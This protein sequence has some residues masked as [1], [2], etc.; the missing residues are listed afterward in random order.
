MEIEKAV[1]AADAIIVCL[2]KS[3]ITKEGY[4]QKEIKTALDFADYKPEGTVFIIPV[5]LED[6]KPPKRF[7]KWQYEDYFNDKR[8]RAFKRLLVS[9]R[10]RADSLGLQLTL[11]DVPLD[12][13]DLS[14]QVFNSLMRV[15]LTNVGD[16]LDLLEMGETAV[17]SIRNFGEKSLDELR[18]KMHEKGYTEKQD[19][20]Q[21]TVSIISPVNVEITSK[22]TEKK[23]IVESQTTPL[24]A[25]P[26]PEWITANKI[27]LSNGMEFMRVPT[28]KFLMG[29]AKENK[30][31]FDNEYPQQ[32]I[33]I[34]YDY[35]M[36]RFPVTNEFYNAYVKSKGVDHPVSDWEIKKDHPVV[37]VKWI[38]ALE[39]CQ[40][41]ND[42]FK[43][44]LPSEL[45]LRLP[46]EAEWEKAAR[47]KDGREYPWGDTLDKNKC[48]SREGDKGNTTPVDFY[49]PHGNSPYGCADMIGNIW[50]WT[51]SLMKNYPYNT[52]D[53]R[54]DEQA[55]GPRVLR[56]GADYLNLKRV[57]C[58]Y[59]NWSS[60]HNTNVSIGFR[61]CLAPPLPK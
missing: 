27:T 45:V 31:A 54:E 3:S 6:C 10:T 2:S 52:N 4:V 22:S 50:E 56:G 42:Q 40:W 33:D 32:S 48:N 49:S 19:K 13:L 59:R 25:H 7:S 34:P 9:L 30:V 11:L 55:N 38:P 61:M 5:R 47:G 26:T 46:T 23:S 58:A 60:L 51:N 29:S 44:E 39:Y 37:M 41:L 14:E 18:R 20:G 36:A 28:G 15:G 12:V 21:K 8:E 57:R 35:W 16:A 24:L 53:G 17:M 1:D 43:G